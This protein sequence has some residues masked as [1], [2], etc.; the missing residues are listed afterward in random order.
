[1]IT[2]KK[3]TIDTIIKRMGLLVDN[4]DLYLNIFEQSNILIGPLIYFHKRTLQLLNENGLPAKAIQDLHFSEYLYA[5]LTAWGMNSRGAVLVSFE[6]F[7]NSLKILGNKFDEL[8]SLR[9]ESLNTNE[10]SNIIDTLWFLIDKIEVSDT[11]SKIVAGSKTLHHILPNLVPPIDRDHTAEFFRWKNYMQNK[12][13][14]MFIDIFPRFVGIAQSINK[15][16]IPNYLGHG[17]NTNIPK[18]IDNAIIG[19]VITELRTCRKRPLLPPSA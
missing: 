3:T 4:I 9:I 18:I 14:E 15:K 5:T 10:L 13:K 6:K 19:F 11:E 1:M 2:R 7:W 16:Q 8:S 12:Q 17:S